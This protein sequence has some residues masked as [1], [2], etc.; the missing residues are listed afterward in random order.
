MYKQMVQMYESNDV[1][2]HEEP[3]INTSS[4]VIDTGLMDSAW[5][6]KCHD[7]KHSGRSPFSTINNNGA[8]LWKFQA[9]TWIE[10]GPIIGS[11]GTIYFGDFSGNF[12]ALNPDGTLKWKYMTG[13]WI[14]STP[15]I[16]EDGTVYIGSMDCGLY[17][18]SYTHLRAHET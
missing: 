3:E 10:E 18:V 11:D 7:T 15:A 4:D 9:D 1:S 16:D 12:Y 14:W 2:F 17:A 8:E 13:G 5:P 6:M